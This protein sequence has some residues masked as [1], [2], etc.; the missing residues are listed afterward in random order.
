M[1]KITNY[2]EDQYEQGD[3]PTRADIA[4]EVGELMDKM[5][6]TTDDLQKVVDTYPHDIEVE[7]YVKSELEYE[8]EQQ[9][10]N[11]SIDEVLKKY[12]VTDIVNFKKEL[13]KIGYKIEQQF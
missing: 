2:D 5:L 10:K 8:L 3:E 6:M 7:W 13:R 11:N 12:G 1:K 4:S 9:R